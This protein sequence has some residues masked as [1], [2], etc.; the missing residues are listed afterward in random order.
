MQRSEDVRWQWIGAALLVAVVFPFLI[1]LSHDL[2]R[3]YTITPDADLIFLG[4]ALRLGDGLGQTY[5]DHTGHAYI[6]ILYAWLKVW[7]F[8]GLIPQPSEAAAIA[9]ANI[10]TYIQPLIVAGRGLSMT[11]SSIFTALMIVGTRCMG[12]SRA[13]AI[14]VGLVFATSQGLINQS[15]IMRAD[16][17]S[18]MAVFAV[19]FA[20]VQSQRSHGREHLMWLAVAGA[21]A[22]LAMDTKIQSIIVLLGLP[23][24][25]L[26]LGL[27]RRPPPLESVSL[28]TLT[29]AAFAIAIAV[30][31]L[32][33]V[34]FSLTTSEFRGPLTGY[35]G[36]VA[37]LIIVCMV[38]YGWLY[39]ETRIRQINGALALL[40]GLS[41]GTAVLFVWHSYRLLDAMVHFV[42]YMTVFSSSVSRGEVSAALFIK[43]IRVL[44]ERHFLNLLT[45]TGIL[46]LLSVLAMALLYLRGD[47][48]RAVLVFLLVC[49]G[50]AVETAFGLRGYRMSYHIYVD[51]WL[52]LAV[53]IGL[54]ALIPWLQAGAKTLFAGG[55]LV[56]TGWLTVVSLGDGMIPAQAPENVCY[57]ARTYLE[58]ALA[59]RF[60]SY[61]PGG[62]SSAN[63]GRSSAT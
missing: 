14:A 30:P 34:G 15:L 45:P 49:L 54:D 18:A 3:S 2:V 4:Q 24:L 6:L 17:L 43:L 27:Y 63:K 13:M 38:L 46:E 61:C 56:L 57:Q 37:G 12:I 33:V 36:L 10:D 52:F 9:T 62:Q 58:P 55:V 21:A 29:F 8:F 48:K 50:L 28:G 1:G 31:F 7:A 44:I 39:R 60:E 40:A 53:A 23:V 32:G 59:D 16:L 25:A 22:I 51:P 35:Q 47:R 41:L 5:H 20:L 42:E 19:F 26:A 11:L